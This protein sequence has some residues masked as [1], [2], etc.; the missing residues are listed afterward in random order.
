ML[1][2]YNKKNYKKILKSIETKLNT[3]DQEIAEEYLAWLDKKTLYLK[4]SLD[5]EGYGAQPDSLERGDVVWVEFGINVGTELS[6]YKTK[7]HYGV[8]W[9]VDLG[10][11]IILP[12]SSRETNGS[13]LNYDI[14]IIEGL[15]EKDNTHSFLKIDAIRSVS[16]R[17]IGRMLNKQNGKI[18]LKDETIELIKK[19]LYDSLIK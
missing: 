13:L 5:K 14:G 9:N 18:H 17:R 16:K 6:D 7:G 3:I 12:L 11:V 8:V 2:S 4:K 15:N 1:F 10:N 19:A